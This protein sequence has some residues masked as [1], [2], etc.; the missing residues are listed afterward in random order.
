VASIYDLTNL[1]SVKSWANVSGSTDDGL[2]GSLI[3]SMSVKLLDFLGRGSILPTSYS[4]VRDGIGTHSMLML[5]NWP[6]I[7]V[8]SLSIDGVAIAAAPALSAGVTAQTGWVLEQN[9]PFPPGHPTS[10]YLY[11]AS[12]SRYKQ[13]IFVNYRAGYQVSDE[14]ATVPATPFQVS[15]WQSYGPWASDVKVV[16]AA[17]GALLT[18]VASTPS[19]G[20]YSAAS[21]VYTFSV[22]DVGAQVLISYG[23]I[24]SPLAEAC[25]E[26]VAER[27]KYRDRIGV[28]S[29][30]LG[31]QETIRFA[32]NALSE[33][34]MQ[35]LES[36]RA[37]FIP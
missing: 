8:E 33:H 4:E 7:S 18:K 10:V 23:F 3:T 21:G 37:R 16:Y 19:M 20:Q 11:G 29:K 17:T 13:G 36:Y 6:V 5:R 1:Q 2:L 24:P 27:Y 15:V 14:P 25:T 22:G 9:D 32:R 35:S 34:V 28:E 12:P 26:L 31:G 30:T